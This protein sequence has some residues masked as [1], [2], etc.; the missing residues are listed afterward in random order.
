MKKYKVAI[1][2]SPITDG[3]SVRGVGYY[4]K[5]L[6]NA[7]QKIK[8][9]QLEIKLTT[10]RSE[11]GDVD[12]IHYP[13]FDP[14]KLTLPKSTI[15]TIVTVHDLIPRQF[16]SHFPVGIRGELYWLAQSYRLRNVSHIITVSN[17]SKEIIHQILRISPQK[18]SVT[19]EAANPSYHPVLD[20]NRRKEVI[21]KYNLPDKFVL[22]V[23]DINWNKNVPTLVKACLH[24]KIPLVIAGSAAIKKT[25]SHPWTQDILWVQSQK[26][27]NLITTG[28]IDDTDMPVVYSVATVYCQPSYAEGFGLPVLE[29]MQCGCPVVT[30][31]ESSLAEVAGSAA[32]FFNPHSQRDLEEKLKQIF[33]DTSL[34]KKLSLLGI[35]QSQ[36]FSWEKT[37]KDTL[38][39]Y[40][41]VLHEKS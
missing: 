37:A 3:N 36:K 27:K 25:I 35:K 8:P 17:Y 9:N 4:T 30:N 7:L 21:S 5:H 11:I 31:R 1:D 20:Q 14:F 32:L 28:F 6:T 19:L 38:S 16:K 26:N 39:V 29:A 15:P 34:Q 2:V 22:Y 10:Q 13:F 12:L 24:Q 33:Q 18:I 40:D 23:G 41:R